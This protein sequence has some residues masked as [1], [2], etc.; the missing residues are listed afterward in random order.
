MSERPFG[1]QVDVAASAIVYPVDGT[2]SVDESQHLHLVHHVHGL[3]IA[4]DH[5]HG[6]FLALGDPCRCHLDTVDVE[7]ADEHPRNHEFLMRQESH[8]AGLLTIT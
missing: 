3:G 2:V 7:L 8:A 1:Q 6:I 5:L 4:A